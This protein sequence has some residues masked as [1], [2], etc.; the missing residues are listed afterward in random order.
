MGISATNSRAKPLNQQKLACDFCQALERRSLRKLLNGRRTIRRRELS[1]SGSEKFRFNKDSVV[2]IT[3]TRAK[4]STPLRRNHEKG[5]HRASLAP[6]NRLG[7]NFIDEIVPRSFAT[8]ASSVHLPHRIWVYVCPTIYR[9]FMTRHTAFIAEPIH[10][11]S[12]CAEFVEER[13]R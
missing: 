10:E 11:V 4:Y 2:L 3:S 8:K 7:F 9:D 1:C 6:H 13:M 5:C 12:P